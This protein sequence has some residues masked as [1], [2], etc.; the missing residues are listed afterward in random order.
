M[1]SWHFVLIVVATLST[2]QLLC[3]GLFSHDALSN[4]FSA[5][6]LSHALIENP[7]Q[8]EQLLRVMLAAN[9]DN[10]PVTLLYQVTL[11]LQLVSVSIT[12]LYV[13]KSYNRRR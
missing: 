6:A 11:L 7:V 1:I 2:G 4:W 8:R 12:P 3:G 13:Y 10:P 9:P 5:V